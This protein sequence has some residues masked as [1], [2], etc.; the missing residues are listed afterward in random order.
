[1]V[2]TLAFLL[3]GASGWIGGKM[4]FEHKIGVVENVDR[5]ATAIGQRES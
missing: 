1:V 3:L 4:T 5:E 2:S